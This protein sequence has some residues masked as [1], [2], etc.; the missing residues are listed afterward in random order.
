MTEISRPDSLSTLIPKDEIGQ[1]QVELDVLTS[2]SEDEQKEHGYFHTLREILQ[3]PKTWRETG[4]EL[5]SAADE[6]QVTING[7][8]AL[9]LTGSGSSEYAGECLRLPLQN[10]LSVPVQTIGG[11]TLLT[12]GGRAIAPGR[13]GLM[14]SFARSG[15]SPESV[16]AISLMLETEPEI[17]QLV[18]TCNAQGHA[19]TAYVGDPRVKVI[20][21]AKETN[22]RSLVMTSSFT[23]M[24]LAAGFLGMLRTPDRY[25]ALTEGLSRRAETL[26]HTHLDTL[27]A[28]ARR[29]FKT[30]MYLASPTRFGAARE[31]SL[32][33]LEMTAGQMPAN[34]ETY[35]G[36]RHGPMSGVHSDTLVV[37]F[38]SS[39]PMVRAY[40]CDLI[41]EL[42]AKRLG[43][44]KLI[45]GDHVPTDLARNEDVTID[46]HG[47]AEL[48]DDNMPI[49]DVVVG[50]LLAF[51]RCMKEGLKPD[52][53]SKD[54]VINRVVQG[55]KLHLVGSTA[56]HTVL[57]IQ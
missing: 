38:L 9:A 1:K 48:G 12:H 57:L 4:K 11:G 40:E 20:V 10:S 47:L 44:A 18:V 25:L 6:L 23:N 22:D 21:L 39:D 30:V 41:Q 37:C 46:C 56:Q 3:Q 13:P 2:R 49:L 7:I 33:M 34:C 55:F 26:L 32:K 42:N 36:L 8:K 28:L 53:P 50:Q 54:G 16:G 35:L 31:A 43:F 17:R 15:D 24:V 27:A 51:F 14:V 19:A 52:S 45:F 5:A 29:D